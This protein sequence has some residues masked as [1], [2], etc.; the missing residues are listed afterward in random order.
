MRL[1][2]P[3]REGRRFGLPCGASAGRHCGKW[4]FASARPGMSRAPTVDGG[5][6]RLPS[7]PSTPYFV[8]PRTGVRVVEGTGLEN[9]HTRKGIVGSNPTLSVMTLIFLLALQAAAPA[10]SLADLEG[11]YC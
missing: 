5:P 2:P 7:G 9:R 3:L 8:S 6:N 1:L 10:A 4:G 11:N